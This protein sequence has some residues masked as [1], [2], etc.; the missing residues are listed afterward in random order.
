MRYAGNGRNSVAILESI[1]LLGEFGV[2]NEKIC[3]L[4]E[5]ITWGDWCEQG[6]PAYGGNLTYRIPLPSIPDGRSFLSIPEWRGTAIGVRINGS[7][8]QVL[9]CPPYRVELTGFL[10]HDGS[11][12]AEICIYGHR[13]NVFGPFYSNEKWPS[14]TGPAQFRIYETEKKQLVPCGLLSAP[15]IEIEN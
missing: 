2:S 15:C 14:W 8:E 11:D 10:K 7:G 5:T 4:P 6:F 12:T 13:R 3:R 9:I 1:F